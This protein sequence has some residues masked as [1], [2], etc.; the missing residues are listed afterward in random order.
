MTV[1]PDAA[2]LDTD[3]VE[4]YLTAHLP[5]FR[6]PLTAEKFGVGQSNPTFKLTS[7][8]GTLVLRRKPPGELLKSA[9]AVDRE[10]RVQK[11]LAGTDV[12]VARMH[13]LCEDESVIGSMFYV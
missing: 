1:Q 12:P 4:R 8:S 9:H 11:A 5:G 13:L 3:A 10:F 7:P 6:G 2:S